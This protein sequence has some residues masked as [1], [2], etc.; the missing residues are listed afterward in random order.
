M[1]AINY[2]AKTFVYM[3]SNVKLII[4]CPL[5]HCKITNFKFFGEGFHRNF[6]FILYKIYDI[7]RKDYDVRCKNKAYFLKHPFFIL[8]F[9]FHSFQGREH[10]YWLN[11]FLVNNER[12]TWKVWFIQPFIWFSFREFI[13]MLKSFC[14]RDDNDDDGKGVK[15]GKYFLMYLILLIFFWMLL[16]RLFDVNIALNTINFRFHKFLLEF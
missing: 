15:I 2:N 13:C 14:V 10:V 1:V 6:I 11:V 8:Y 5:A 4:L 12:V 9:F 16:I 3:H 7:W